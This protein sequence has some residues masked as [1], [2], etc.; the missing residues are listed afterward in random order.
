[1]FCSTIVM[2]AFEKVGAEFVDA[3][4]TLMIESKNPVEGEKVRRFTV[5]QS[6]ERAIEGRVSTINENNPAVV[7]RIASPSLILE[8]FVRH[9]RVPA[10]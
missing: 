8:P 10:W 6:D 7:F 4:V 1:M 5:D 9:I 2:E 3:T